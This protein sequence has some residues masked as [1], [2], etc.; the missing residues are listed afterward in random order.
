MLLSSLIFRSVALVVKTCILYLIQSYLANAFTILLNKYPGLYKAMDYIFSSLGIFNTYLCSIV[1]NLDGILKKKHP[2]VYL[3]IRY[4]YSEYLELIKGNLTISNLIIITLYVLY[5]SS[6]MQLYVVLLLNSLVR[7]YLTK[8]TYIKENY[9]VLHSILLDISYL[10]TTI[11]IFYFI[12][13]MWL[14]VILPFIKKKAFI[15]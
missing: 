4:V 15:F 11:F 8:D 5:D 7:E 12:N 2:N 3:V 6:N 1:L 9:P 10:V 13:T 14:K